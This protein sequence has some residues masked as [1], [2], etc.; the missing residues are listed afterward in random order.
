[1]QQSPE[2]EARAYIG[3][4]VDRGFQLRLGDNPEVDITDRMVVDSGRMYAANTR[5]VYGEMRADAATIAFQT[6]MN[7]VSSS[8]DLPEA[9]GNAVI[10]PPVLDKA[11]DVIRPG[12]DA[13]LYNEADVPM[14]LSNLYHGELWRAA[15]QDP[16]LAQLL[17]AQAAAALKD[18]RWAVATGHDVRWGSMADCP[19]GSA[20][21]TGGRP[22]KDL[23]AFI[24]A[25][26][27]SGNMPV[28]HTPAGMD[29]LD[30]P[31]SDVKGSR[32]A[33]K[34][35]PVGGICTE[36]LARPGEGVWSRIYMLGREKHIDIGRFGAVNLS[37]G[38]TERIWG[39]VSRNWPLMEAVMY[40][41]SRDELMA[42][43]MSNHISVS[44]APD[45]QS[46]NG[47]MFA[48]AGMTDALGYQVHLCGKHAIDESIQYKV[49]NK[50]PVHGPYER[51]V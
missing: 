41:V 38:E 1:M 50:L 37:E 25:L 46:A 42:G 22:I 49:E 32:H 35:F 31:Y 12:R 2:Q 3:W 5:W 4:M 36:A 15:G 27:L 34:Y 44:Y 28:E 30:R 18:P 24:T 20:T 9:M 17:G 47:L 40:G 16:A 33:W 13:S 26:N 6:G 7:P 19:D 8:S 39:S 11:G 14:L 10:R 29:N 51:A 21:Y 45:A 23:D 48:L 43:H